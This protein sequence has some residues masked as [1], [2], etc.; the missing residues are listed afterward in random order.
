MYLIIEKIKSL[1]FEFKYKGREALKDTIDW[2][3]ENGWLP[4]E[5]NKMGKEV[6]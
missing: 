3:M 1:G 5:Y 4:T 6:F 2:Y